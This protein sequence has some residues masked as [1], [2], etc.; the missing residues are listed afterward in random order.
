MHLVL[1]SKDRDFCNQMLLKG[2]SGLP[3]LVP[4]CQD[5]LYSLVKVQQ[6]IL[7]VI[8]FSKTTQRGEK[9]DQCSQEADYT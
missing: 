8:S 7:L 1:Q 3:Q 5:M 9:K 4:Y 2:P 6:N